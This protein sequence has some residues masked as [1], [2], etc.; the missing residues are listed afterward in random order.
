M[1]YSELKEQIKSAPISSVIGHYISLNKKGANY[2]A[3]CPFHT[4][5]HPSLKV[6]DNKGLFKCFACDTAGDHISFVEK[7][8]RI[9]FKDAIK[10]IA[11]ILGYATDDLDKEFS[12][13]KQDLALRVLSATNKIYRKMVTEHSPEEFNKFI[14]S[15]GLTIDVATQFSLGFAPKTNVLSQY[16]KTLPASQQKE[17]IKMAIE[18]GLIRKNETDADT[19]DT[20]RERILF[21]I[22]DQTGH[23]RGFGSRAT[24]TY[25]KAK[26]LNSQESFIFNKRNILYGFHLAKNHIRER[27]QVILT[28][29]YM[30]TITMHQFD[31]KNT[32][33]LMGIALSDYAIGLL[34]PLASQF[35]LALDSDNAG[36]KA[37]EKINES[38]LE[39]GILAKYLDFKPHKDPDEFL[40]KEGRLTLQKRLDEAP[41][42]LDVIINQLIPENIPQVSDQ[43]LVI[44]NKVFQVLAP[45]KE[46]LSAT[47]RVITTAKRLNFQS[48]A[49]SIQ[50]SYV[51]FL[52]NIN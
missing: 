32:V 25:Q 37:M 2:E 20:F 51:T 36:F 18:I 29:G 15:R 50:Q 7:Y 3:L 41:M 4:D 42:F 43:K 8:K 31:F 10:E 30:D 48:S 19:F 35:V 11:G 16:L 17:A 5:S 28:E 9:D 34:K 1:G 23:V 45:L 49:D 47:E 14:T 38:L 6:N 13:P 44:L 27:D 22:W 52:N 26:Y 33:A 46:S 39:K 40:H 12:N 24:Q 21:P